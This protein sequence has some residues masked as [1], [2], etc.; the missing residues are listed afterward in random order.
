M[1]TDTTFEIKVQYEDG[2]GSGLYNLTLRRGPANK[3]GEALEK[4]LLRLGGA[5]VE[6]FV[7]GCYRG[8]HGFIVYYISI[9]AVTAVVINKVVRDIQPIQ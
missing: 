9:P 2:T 1:T 3:V 4:I 8:V 7:G 5:L 6:G